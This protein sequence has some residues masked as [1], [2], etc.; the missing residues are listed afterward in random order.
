MLTTVYAIHDIRTRKLVRVALSGSPE[1]QTTSGEV[2]LYRSLAG[3]DSEIIPIE[4]R[5]KY[6]RE[7]RQ[8]VR[9]LDDDSVARRLL[10]DTDDIEAEMDRAEDR[11]CQKAKDRRWLEEHHQREKVIEYKKVANAIARDHAEAVQSMSINYAW[12]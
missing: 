8:A 2:G 4:E 10:A 1:A 6:L 7:Y 3:W 12:R 11:K 5:R 9:R